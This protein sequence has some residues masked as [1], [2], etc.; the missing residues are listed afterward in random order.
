MLILQFSTSADLFDVCAAA[1]DVII[2]VVE[3][4]S[5]LKYF[6][7]QLGGEIKAACH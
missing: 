2:R 4:I 1:S 5:P 7:N 6:C 3:F